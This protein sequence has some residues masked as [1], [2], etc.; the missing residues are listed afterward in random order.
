MTINFTG[1]TLLVS[2]GFDHETLV[3]YQ[4]PEDKVLIINLKP[5]DPDCHDGLDKVG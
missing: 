1:I 2:Y 3:I 4:D 5:L